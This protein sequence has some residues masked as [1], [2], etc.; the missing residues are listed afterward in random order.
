MTKKRLVSFEELIAVHLTPL[1]VDG[2]FSLFILRVFS[3]S[4]KLVFKTK[5]SDHK[6][7]QGHLKH[8]KL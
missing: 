6:V 8:E 7:Q 3:F 1:Q 4:Q 5:R 2:R